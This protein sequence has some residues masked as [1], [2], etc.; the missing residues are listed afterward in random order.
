MEESVQDILRDIK[1]NVREKISETDLNF[2]QETLSLYKKKI[3]F[4]FNI[5]CEQLKIT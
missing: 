1:N 2:M 5:F 3:E 4:N